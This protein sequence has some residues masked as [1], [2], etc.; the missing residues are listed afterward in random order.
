MK[1]K[2]IATALRIAALSAIWLLQTPAQ[3]GLVSGNWD[4]EFGSALPGLSWAVHAEVLV[5][6]NT[7]ADLAGTQSTATGACAGAT[8]QGV[9]LRLFDSNY[10]PPDWSA[11]DAYQSVLPSMLT[12]GYCD[13]SVSS[14]PAYTGRCDSFGS[15]FNLSALRIEDGSVAGLQTSVGAVF[16]SLV[17]VGGVPQAWP[18]SA[19]GYDFSLGFTVNG[20]QLA[21]INCPGGP[22]D[23]QLDGLRQFLI[24]YTSND[25]STPKFTDAAGNALGVRLDARGQVL[26]RSTSINAALPVP[27]PGSLAL[28]AAALAAAALV[29]R[30]RR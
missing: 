16:G 7:C 15:F 22:I 19:Q 25:T 12:Y 11:P 13:T 23:S 18:A 30:R 20:P 9:F 8:V 17:T 29:R 28:A 2:P 27:E 14:N 3:A 21:C 10:T 6:D 5:P 4:P 26:G 1:T 24:T